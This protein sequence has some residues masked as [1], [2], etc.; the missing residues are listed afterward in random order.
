MFHVEKMFY[1]EY[2]KLLIICGQHANNLALYVHDIF[3]LS[4]QHKIDPLQ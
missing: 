4:Y 1:H 3:K 2:G